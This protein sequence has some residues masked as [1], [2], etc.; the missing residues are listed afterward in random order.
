MTTKNIKCWNCGEHYSQTQPHC[1]RCKKPHKPPA[2][3]KA[4]RWLLPVII[5][6][7]IVLGASAMLAS[8]LLNGGTFQAQTVELHVTDSTDICGTLSIPAGYRLDQGMVNAGQVVIIPVNSLLRRRLD[9]KIHAG[10]VNG[11][12]GEFN[13]VVDEEFLRGL[14]IYNYARVM[15]KGTGRPVD[16]SKNDTAVMV[17]G[18]SGATAVLYYGAWQDFPAFYEYN[19][20]LKASDYT[21]VL[22]QALVL[23]E[24]WPS[25]QVKIDEIFHSYQKP[26]K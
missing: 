15:E 12:T 26:V 24:G 14:A 7:V 5:A 11:G 23:P 1:P 13:A 6:G 22:L 20:A 4:P 21:S 19:L 18:V 8:Y 10:C 17:N 9:F 2:R 25:Q 16:L 3:S